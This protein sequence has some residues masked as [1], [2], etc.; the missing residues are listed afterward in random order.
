MNLK[1]MYDYN[2]HFEICYID[3]IHCQEQ[4]QLL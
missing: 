3:A 1:I 4:R 2:N